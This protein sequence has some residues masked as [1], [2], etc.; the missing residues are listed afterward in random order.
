MSSLSS[1][2]R[3]VPPSVP[4]HSNRTRHVIGLAPHND[5]IDI[6]KYIRKLEA[7]LADLGVVSRARL[8]G[9]AHASGTEKKRESGD[10]GHFTVTLR[11]VSHA[12]LKLVG[13]CRILFCAHKS[14]PV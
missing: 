1:A 13:G 3:V 11:N 6:A 14:Q 7:D 4:S 5:G 8:S 10:S 2:G 9:G 12:F